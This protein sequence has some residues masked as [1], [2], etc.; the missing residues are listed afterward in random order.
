[1]PLDKTDAAYL[2]VSRGKALRQPRQRPQLIGN[3]NQKRIFADNLAKTIP[4]GIGTLGNLWPL[5]E[6]LSIPAE[7]SKGCGSLTK[8]KIMPDKAASACR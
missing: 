3:M 4:Q 6:I 8:G 2:N 1:M 7:K 5:M